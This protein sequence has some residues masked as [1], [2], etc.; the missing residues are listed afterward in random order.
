MIT[1][2][3][4]AAAIRVALPAMAGVCIGSLN[5][6]GLNHDLEP[7]LVEL[8]QAA[9]YR[10]K[11]SSI[12]D[13]DFIFNSAGVSV[14]F[15]F[16][17]DTRELTPSLSGKIQKMRN[18]FCNSYVIV[19]LANDTNNT[20]FNN[21]Y[22]S[23]I[24]TEIGTPPY[25]AVKDCNTGLQKM[26]RMAH[27]HAECKRQGTIPMIDIERKQFVVSVEACLA[28]ISSIP[29]LEPHD[30]YSLQQGIGSIEAISRSS[31]DDIMATTDLS[32]EKA[33]AV[34][35]FF[36]NTSYSFTPKFD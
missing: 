36:W 23:S 32:L 35:N 8:L 14:A 13:S 18:T 25:I 17:A 24:L 19:S 9:D 3:K 34:V 12:S 10:L 6:R 20:N 33:K 15:I 30:A 11:F 29:H 4:Q 31:E 26:I 27:V 22:L 28:A 16:V 1:A 21:F 2:S 5:W 7:I